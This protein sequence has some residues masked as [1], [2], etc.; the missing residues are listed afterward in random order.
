[1]TVDKM[2]S[3][4][5]QVSNA[6]IKYGGSFVAHLGYTLQH[7]DM[8]NMMRIK[9]AFPD[10]WGDYKAKSEAATARETGTG[11]VVDENKL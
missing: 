3:E 9:H 4:S 10:Y 5:L 1:M 7:A 8:K 6:M 11:G 2:I